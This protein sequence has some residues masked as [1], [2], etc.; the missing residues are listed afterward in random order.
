MFAAGW[1]SLVNWNDAAG[2]LVVGAPTTTTRRRRRD[3]DDDDDDD[4][5]AVGAGRDVAAGVTVAVRC[6]VCGPVRPVA[7]IRPEN[8]AANAYSGAVGQCLAFR[9]VRSDG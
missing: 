7:E 1:G 3:L 4:A 5:A 9:L 2:T 6:G 8:A